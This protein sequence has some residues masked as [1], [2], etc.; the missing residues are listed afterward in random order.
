MVWV[1]SDACD[2]LCS[3]KVSFSLLQD[4]KKMG[5]QKVAIPQQ[6]AG[7]FIFNSELARVYQKNF[8]AIE[9]EKCFCNARRQSCWMT[10]IFFYQCNVLFV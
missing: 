8:D 4:S 2:K 1:N 10:V 9:G 7:G 5:E 6:E 3:E